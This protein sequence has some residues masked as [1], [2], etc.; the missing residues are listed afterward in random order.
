MNAFNQAFIPGYTLFDL[1]AA[2]AGNFNDVD[3][4]L[5]LN[6]QNIA[7]KEYFSSTGA[8][9]IAQ[10]PPRVMKISLTMRF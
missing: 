1:G 7:D 9:V 10:A 3:M 2:Y 5:R 6:C 4:T 8:N